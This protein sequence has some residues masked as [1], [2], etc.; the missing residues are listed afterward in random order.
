M[1]IGTVEAIRASVAKTNA[2]HVWRTAQVTD[3]REAGDLV[4][5][6]RGEDRIWIDLSLAVAIGATA[7]RIR[8]R[9]V[10]QAAW[11]DGFFQWTVGREAWIACAL[12]AAS[13]VLALVA[14]GV[15]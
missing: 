15:L 1:D 14:M 10:Q 2:A 13:F 9:D 11:H 4:L 7:H 6:A 3:L 5:V 8:E 12:L